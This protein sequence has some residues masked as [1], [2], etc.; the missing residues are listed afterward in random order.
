[1]PATLALTLGTAPT[2]G[3]VHPGR[4]EGLPGDDD[5]DRDLDRR[6]R[7][8]EHRDSSTAD[9]GHLVNGTFSLPQAVQ[10]RAGATAAF[11]DVGSS[12]APLTLKTWTAPTSN[13]TV[14]LEFKQTIGAGDAL[15][16]GAYAKTLTLTLSTTSP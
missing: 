14:P 3:V 12:A 8:P 15:R 10:A 5:R 4:D 7:G 13:E 6:R 9:A 11:A 1:M 2:F 16:T